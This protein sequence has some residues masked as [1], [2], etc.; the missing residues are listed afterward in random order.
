MVTI[1]EKKMAIKAGVD[2]G[3]GLTF[4]QEQLNSELQDEI[5]NIYLE[6]YHPLIFKEAELRKIAINVAQDIF[7]KKM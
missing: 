6:N 3:L 7:I 1:E 5:T 2:I 4:T